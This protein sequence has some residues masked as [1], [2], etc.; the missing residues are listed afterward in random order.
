M[1]ATLKTLFAGVENRAD[2][3]V[4]D[5]F[6]LELIDQKIRETEASLKAAKATLASLIQRQK[7]ETRQ[8]EALQNRIASMTERAKEALDAGNDALAR[9]AAD[10]IATMENELALR[11]TT[12]E[13]LEQKV[14]RLKSSVEAGHRRIVDLKQGA[15]QARAVRREQDIQSRLNH[16]LSGSDAASEAEDLISRV[17]TR[18]DPFEQA[19]ILKG[20]DADLGHDGLENRMAEAGYGP[21]TRVTGNAVLDRLKTKK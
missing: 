10:A 21:A 18:D 19:E 2:E 8:V 16:T 17:L 20:I 11:T 9:E 13:R 1:F 12:S 15:I 6:A 5:H 7:S 14:L 4:K 3:R